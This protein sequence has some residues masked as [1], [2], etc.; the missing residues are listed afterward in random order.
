M[1]APRTTPPR[2][3]DV[4]ALF[5]QLAPMARSATRLHPRPGS[6]TPPVRRP[7]ALPPT[8]P[9]ATRRAPAAPPPRIANTARQLRRRAAALARRRTV[10]A[11]RRSTHL[12]PTH[13]PLAGGRTARAP[14]PAGS[15]KPPA[16]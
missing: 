2:P 9:D 14:Q 6:P 1:T 10:A 3:F 5:P 16:P 7:R 11:L 12:G 15:A 13:G 4:T 8:S